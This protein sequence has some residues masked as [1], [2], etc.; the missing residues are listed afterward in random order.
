M[1]LRVKILLS[2]MLTKE[3]LSD[4]DIRGR[5]LDILL[6]NERGMCHRISGAG[7]SIDISDESFRMLA[8]VARDNKIKAIKL[9]RDCFVTGTGL[10]GQKEMIEQIME[11]DKSPII[12]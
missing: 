9:L 10:K 11:S 4:D 5:A 12:H 6:E 7:V 2:D 3:N 1:D 8:M